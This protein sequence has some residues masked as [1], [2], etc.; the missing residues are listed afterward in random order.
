MRIVN[1][2][3]TAFC[4]RLRASMPVAYPKSVRWPR[5][6]VEAAR[7]VSSVFASSGAG[8]GRVP[9]RKVTSGSPCLREDGNELVKGATVRETAQDLVLERHP[10]PGP[11]DRR[12][13]DLAGE[14]RH[15]VA[16]TE[17]D[18]P[19]P[20]RQ[21]AAYDRLARRAVHLAVRGVRRDATR[22][23]GEAQLPDL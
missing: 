6:P 19:G 12:L 8:S 18:I 13:V 4:G 16:V 23:D 7:N 15:P 5:V 22:P 9:R 11:L 14:H 1:A 20:D 2:G 3:P 17:H 10:V 21:A